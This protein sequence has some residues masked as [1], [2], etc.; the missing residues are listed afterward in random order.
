MEI[1]PTSHKNQ[2]SPDDETLVGFA[3]SGD[4]FCT[5]LHHSH[6]QRN[7]LMVIGS[8]SSWGETAGQAIR[9]VNPA[10]PGFLHTPT[11]IPFLPCLVIVV[12]VEASMPRK[13]PKRSTG[14]TP[15]AKCW[16]L[17]DQVED[18]AMRVRYANKPSDLSNPI[19]EIRQVSRRLD[20][21]REFW[22]L[23][24]LKSRSESLDLWPKLFERHL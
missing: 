12:T 4:L 3:R 22:L 23:R 6:T 7:N 15:F 11:Q 20:V 1:K 19:T 14:G 18:I 21:L 16:K 17:A 2:I 5:S 24:W 9:R 10:V 13:Q 8:A